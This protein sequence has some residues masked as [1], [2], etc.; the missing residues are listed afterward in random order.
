MTLL[1]SLLRVLKTAIEVPIRTG[2]S[3]WTQMQEDP[4]SNFL[5]LLA[6]LIS[7]KL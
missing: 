2:F 4:L 7:S 3:S 5:K 1:S 6:K